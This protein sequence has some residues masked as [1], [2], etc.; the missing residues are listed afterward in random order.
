MAGEDASA[1]TALRLRSPPA[2]DRSEDLSASTFRI[3]FSLSPMLMKSTILCETPWLRLRELEFVDSAGRSR[4]W[5]F[6]QRP[7]TVGAVTVIA[8]LQQ[9]DEFVLVRQYRPPVDAYVIEFPA[10]LVDGNEAPY[11]TALRELK[12][13]T[14]YHGEPVSTSPACPS[15]AGLTDEAIQFV[16]VEVTESGAAEPEEHEDI[17]VIMV[18]RNELLSYLQS[19]SNAGDRVDARLWAFAEGIL[20]HAT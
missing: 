9:S 15:S 5:S 12:E 18:G 1:F 4:T 16:H 19:R 17:E 14:G 3:L 11:A 8:H 20:F 10:G 2:C 13:E 7:N 6:A